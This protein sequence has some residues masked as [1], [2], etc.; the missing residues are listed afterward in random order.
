MFSWVAS[1]TRKDPKE[2]VRKCRAEIRAQ[3]RD[4]DRNISNLTLEQRKAERSIREAAKRNDIQ[5]AR[6]L[7][8]ELLRSRKAVAKLAENK[9]TL[10]AL[11]L[12][13]A[14]ARRNIK[15]AET[16]KS[17]A[18]MIESMNKLMKVPK[19]HE[20]MKNMAKE[21]AYAGLISETINEGIESAIDDEDYEEA[22]DEAVNKVLLELTG[23]TMTAAAAV[24]MSRVAGQR[25]AEQ[26]EG[27][28][29]EELLKILQ[30]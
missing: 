22:A 2:V 13:M 16:V 23:E 30:G 18:K 3:K 12:Q 27:V 21:M 26:A 19:L 8:K 25:V 6:F 9:A 17:S 7:A 29:D 14:E 24:P 15:L 10:S 5:S 4:I 20:S 11:D 28:T 1:L